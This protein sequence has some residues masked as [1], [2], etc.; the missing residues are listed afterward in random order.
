MVKE[1]NPPVT[2]QVYLGSGKKGKRLL[3][4]ILRLA[5]NDSFA[6]T[7]VR[8]LKKAEPKLFKGVDDEKD[9]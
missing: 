2:R 8:L 3:D 9:K 1:Y 7:I 5:G 4:N 6:E